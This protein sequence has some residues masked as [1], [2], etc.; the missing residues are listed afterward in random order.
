MSICLFCSWKIPQPKVSCGRD[1]YFVKNP[2]FLF[3]EFEDVQNHVII[4]SLVPQLS[5]WAIRTKL[6]GAVPQVTIVFK[7]NFDQERAGYDSVP[8][9]RSINFLDFANL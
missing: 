2:S 5:L 4:E 9:V 3:W 7:F 6:H 1:N 8:M